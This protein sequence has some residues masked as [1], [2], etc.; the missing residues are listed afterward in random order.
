MG[1][2]TSKNFVA[3][4]VYTIQINSNP[5]YEWMTKSF[6]IDGKNGVSLHFEYL[7]VVEM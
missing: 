3:V 6:E 4:A 2:K 5:E 1:L 7:L